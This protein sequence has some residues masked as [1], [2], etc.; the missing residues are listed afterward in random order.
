MHR[1][2]PRGAAA[3]GQFR[4]L[5]HRE[6]CVAES[7]VAA[8]FAVL[9]QASGWPVGAT[10]ERAAEALGT[11]LVRTVDVAAFVAG[12][13][14][15]EEGSPASNRLAPSRRSAMS[16]LQALN[17]P[18]PK[19]FPLR[20]GGTPPPLTDPPSRASRPPI[21]SAA[22]KPPIQAGVL[23]PG[24]GTPDPRAEALK[25]RGAIET[26]RAQTFQLLMRLQKVL[27]LVTLTLANN[28]GD[29]LKTLQDQHARLVKGID[30][31]K[32]TLS[33]A[34]AD[35]RVI[36]NP[37]AKGDELAAVTAR[38]RRAPNAG[39]ITAPGL[40]APQGKVNGSLPVE[41]AKPL[42]GASSNRHAQG[43]AESDL[44]RKDSGGKRIA[45]FEVRW[46]EDGDQ[47]YTRVLSAITRDAAFRG[48]S[49]DEFNAV[50]TAEPQTLLALVAALHQSYA[51]RHSDRKAGQKL[52][53][54]FSASY[55][56]DPRAGSGS[57]SGKVMSLVNDAVAAKSK[58]A[59]PVTAASGASAM[60]ARFAADA[61][62]KGWSGV[63]FSV[64]NDGR[65]TAVT[66]MERAGSEGARPKGA[67]ELRSPGREGVGNLHGDRRR[68][69][70]ELGRPL[71]PRCQDRR[72][73]VHE[74]V[75]GTRRPEG[76]ASAGSPDESSPRKTSSSWKPGWCIRSGST[77][78]FVTSARRH[79]RRQTR[80]LSRTCPTRSP[81][82]SCPS[83]R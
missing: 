63:N 51:M 82:S 34:E 66:S 27:P 16:L 17:L 38:H 26:R 18:V 37:A 6:R 12:L 72:N 68:V 61:D 25:Q 46:A 32:S 58:P 54:E 23:P 21:A 1:A 52:K 75:Q 81:A 3:C 48:V 69:Q 55:S 50:S 70:R 33:Q 67:P 43:K 41:P 35:L 7:R 73:A 19:L 30:D 49:S 47:F 78:R 45:A 56:K 20:G 13:R 11:A 36:G 4:K 53:I 10:G 59:G 83:A 77:R 57:L 24:G 29:D 80:F 44:S 22:A 42:K 15:T 9:G 76:A 2:K 64:K 14:S 5:C 39:D 31:A 8:C 74:V 60:L 65:A 40:E 62:R 79:W 71:L 28:P